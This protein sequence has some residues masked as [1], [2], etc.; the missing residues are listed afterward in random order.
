MVRR[1]N[2][3]AGLALIALVLRG[4]LRC[5]RCRRPPRAWFRAR[6]SMRKGQP[7]DGA[8]VTIE[9]TGGTGRKFETKT[10]KKGEFIQIGLP[11]GPY[12]VTAEKGQA[13]RRPR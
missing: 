6:S 2:G 12:K 9:Q 4:R 13:R 8:K 10:D 1:I 7:V 3:P 11:S 5:S